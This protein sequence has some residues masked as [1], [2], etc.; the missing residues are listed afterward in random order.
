MLQR[1]VAPS[2]SAVGEGVVRGAVVGG[3]DCY[4]SWQAPP[5]VVCA[6]DLVA[7]TT[8]RPAVEQRRAESRRVGT[9]SL[10]V[11][12]PVPAG[13]TWKQKQKIITTAVH[14]S[15]HC[16]PYSFSFVDFVEIFCLGYH[17]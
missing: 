15:A 9:E 6:P 5:I 10:A 12:V 8:A 1:R 14:F 7:R 11:Q 13:P 3:C 2:S 16:I 17:F 4:G